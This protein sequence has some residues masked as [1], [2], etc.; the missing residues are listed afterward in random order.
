MRTKLKPVII[1]DELFR[2]VY[3]AEKKFV[4]LEYSSDILENKKRYL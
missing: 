1:K 4:K 3:D 2:Y